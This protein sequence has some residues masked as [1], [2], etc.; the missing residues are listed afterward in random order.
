MGLEWD[1]RGYL[2]GYQTNNALI[3]ACPK[4]R[5]TTDLPLFSSFHGDYDDDKALKI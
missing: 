3:W 5:F 2:I 1:V 4:M